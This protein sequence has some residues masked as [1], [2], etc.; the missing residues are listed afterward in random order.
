M[1]KKSD[2]LDDNKS[3]E[4]EWTKCINEIVYLGIF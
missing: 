1:W 3:V 4:V 2:F